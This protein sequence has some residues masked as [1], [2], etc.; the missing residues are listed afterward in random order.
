[1]KFW[2]AVREMQENNCFIKPKDG[3]RNKYWIYW[4]D[5]LNGMCTTQDGGNTTIW[6]EGDSDWIV[7]R[8]DPRRL[9]ENN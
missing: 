5:N 2:E 8:I 9:N 7:L 4:D 3:P 1:M 6:N